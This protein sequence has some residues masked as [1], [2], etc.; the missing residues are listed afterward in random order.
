MWGRSVL[1]PMALPPFFKETFEILHKADNIVTPAKA[2]VHNNSLLIW[3]P[4]YAGM[5][6]KRIFQ[7]TLF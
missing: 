3:I 2:G 4:A 6:P 1:R 5:T 7:R